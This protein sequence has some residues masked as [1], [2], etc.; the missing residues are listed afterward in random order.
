MVLGIWY[1][2]DGWMDRWT[3]KV[4]YRSGCPTLKESIFRTECNSLWD[5]KKKTKKKKEENCKPNSLI[6]T[7]VYR[8]NLV[9]TIPKF[10]KEEIE[11]N[12]SSTL[13][14]EV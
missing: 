14:L 5:E 9:Y 11:K 13:H 8:S 1:A 4:I 3:E 7:L 2:V 10:I 6:Q 12:N